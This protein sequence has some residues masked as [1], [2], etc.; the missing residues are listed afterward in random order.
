MLKKKI[1]FHTPVMF[2]KQLHSGSEIS[3]QK[4]LKAFKSIGYEVDLVM[5]Y[6]KDRKEQI[7]KIKQSIKD[8]VKYEFLYSESSTVPTALTQKHHFPIAPFLDFNFFNFCKKNNIKIGLFYK[9]IHWKFDQ[10]INSVSFLKRKIAEI[11]YK[12]DLIQYEKYVDILYLPSLLMFKHI[13]TSFDKEV[14]ALPPG[15]EHNN[16]CDNQYSSENLNFIYVGGLGELYNLQLFT[17]VI[18]ELKDI[19]FNLCTRENEWNKNK[20]KYKSSA[21]DVYH[22]SGSKLADVYSKSS[23]GVL[24]VKPTPYWEFVMAVKLF[25]YISYKK[26]IIAVKNTAVGNFVEENDIGW[27]LDYNENELKSLIINL[28]NNPS[29]INTKVKNIEKIMHLHTWEAR[30]SQVAK[31][32]TL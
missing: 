21:I 27:A 9:D 22:L 15:F 28:Q 12:Y 11:F 24:F 29:L 16:K 4:M 31:E 1:I 6:V 5:G 32:L 8:G 25:E 17:K 10:Y 13:P 20:I 7:A 14:I 23:I 26:P 18:D 19:R 30:A 2:D 3:A